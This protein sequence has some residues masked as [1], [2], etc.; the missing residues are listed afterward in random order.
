M[1][2]SFTPSQSS[3]G[4]TG[5]RVQRA[6][7]P[8]KRHQPTL[9][10]LASVLRGTRTPVTVRAAALVTARSR[11][12][13]RFFTEP[14]LKPHAIYTADAAVC[15]SSKCIW[16]SIPLFQHRTRR[17]GSLLHPPMHCPQVRRSFFECGSS[18]AIVDVHRAFR[19]ERQTSD[20]SSEDGAQEHLSRPPQHG[21]SVGNRS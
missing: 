12:A 10:R 17:I 3:R 6:S 15:A 5:H 13:Q 19:R 1:R 18:K 8:V 2:T 16:S 7:R 14:S 21:K 11:P 4:A 20:V 9:A